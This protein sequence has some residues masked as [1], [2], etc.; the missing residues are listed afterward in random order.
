MT[1]I[2][3]QQ[4]YGKLI[5][6]IGEAPS[7]AWANKY[8]DWIK[9]PIDAKGIKSPEN[10]CFS[11]TLNTGSYNGISLLGSTIRCIKIMPAD[12]SVD[13][14][15]PKKYDK[16]ENNTLNS[17]RRD[18]DYHGKTTK[19]PNGRKYWLEAPLDDFILE[20]F[21]ED[22]LKAAKIELNGNN[23]NNPSGHKKVVYQAVTDINARETVL[24]DAF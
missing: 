1:D 16:L 11:T 19:M 10:D 13:V 3:D 6:I 4:G 9:R 21:E 23:N 17:P 14:I 2:T 12:E 8:L 5:D 15:M 24:D 22:W 20:E 7:R 18:A